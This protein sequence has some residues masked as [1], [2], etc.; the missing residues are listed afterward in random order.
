M[1][2]TLLLNENTPIRFAIIVMLAGTAG[3]FLMLLIIATLASVSRSLRIVSS[4]LLWIFYLVALWIWRP[5]FALY[6]SLVV[7][8]FVGLGFAL[9]CHASY[10]AMAARRPHS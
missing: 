6:P 5:S 7:L 4:L 1:L 2:T 3:I 8:P 10:R 9:C